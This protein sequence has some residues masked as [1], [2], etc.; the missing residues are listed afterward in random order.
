MEIRLATSNDIPGIMEFIKN[1]WNENHIL[2]NSVEF[3]KY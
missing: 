3:M 2:A 1:N